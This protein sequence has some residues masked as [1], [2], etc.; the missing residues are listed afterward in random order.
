[1]V[2]IY[3]LEVSTFILV[4]PTCGETIVPGGNPFY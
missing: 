1:M 3:F 4:V 2:I